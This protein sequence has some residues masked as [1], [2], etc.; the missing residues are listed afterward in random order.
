M[1]ISKPIHNKYAFRTV[2]DIIYQEYAN[3]YSKCKRY[4][5]RGVVA[6][7]NGTRTL[8]VVKELMKGTVVQ[9]GNRH[10]ATLVLTSVAYVCSPAMAI[11]TNASKVV[12]VCKMVYITTGYIF[13]LFEHVGTVLLFLIDLALFGQPIPTGDSKRFPNWD[14]IEDLINQLLIIGDE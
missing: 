1:L 13:E 7:C 3:T 4:G 5:F 14:E 10:Y 2:D 9:Y 6:F 12:K 11:L 8:D